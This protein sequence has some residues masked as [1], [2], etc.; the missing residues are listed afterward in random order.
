MLVF[1]IN[2]GLMEFQVGYLFLSLLFTVINGLLWF[3]MGTLQNN[4]QLILEFLKALFYINDLPHN[5]ICNIA[6]NVIRHLISGD[7]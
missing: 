5:G 2:L 4:I 6:L 1:F 3:W 7:N